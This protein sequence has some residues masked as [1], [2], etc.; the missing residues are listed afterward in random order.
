MKRGTAII[1]SVYI[2]RGG[3]GK[4]MP[5]GARTRMSALPDRMAGQD[6]AE[7]LRQEIPAKRQI[8]TSLIIG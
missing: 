7:D 8:N 2:H 1:G 6:C 5:V 4:A 3:R